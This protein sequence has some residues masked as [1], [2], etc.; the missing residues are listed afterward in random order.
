MNVKELLD[1][2]GESYP[3]REDMNYDSLIGEL[4]QENSMIKKISYG[5][6]F[7]PVFNKPGFTFLL[8]IGS[9]ITLNEVMYGPKI[10]QYLLNNLADFEIIMK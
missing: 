6:N 9:T 3:E 5:Q 4:R 7:G 2:L 10:R 1:Q 8:E